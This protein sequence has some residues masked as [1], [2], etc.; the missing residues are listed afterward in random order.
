MR[1]FILKARKGPAA[2]ERIKS[3]IGEGSHL[4]VVIHSVLNAFF[5]SNDLRTDVI[6]HVVLESTEDFS[7]IIT[8]DSREHLSFAGFHEEAITR[9]I[10]S[11]LEQSRDLGKDCSKPVCPGVSVSAGSFE[12]L[13][14]G[15]S[16]QYPLYLLDRKGEDVR[17][18]SF[19]ENSAFVFTDHIPMPKKLQ[20]YLQRLGARKIRLGPKMLFAAHCV[21]L[22]QNELDRREF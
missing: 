17:S 5:L 4:E 22:I 18:C 14:K 3:S 10:E 7:R 16:E 9:L 8:F 21:V 15:I 12:K 20:K 2:A 6:F 11:A 13:V 19:G 1:I